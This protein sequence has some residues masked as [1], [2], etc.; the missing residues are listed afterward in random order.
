MKKKNGFVSEFLSYVGIIIGIIISTWALDCFL[1][2]NL[3][4]DGGVTGVSII[5]S[6][7]TSIP[8]G[9]LVF[10]INVPFVYIGYK[11]IGT[12]FLIKSS[13]S[14]ILFSIALTLFEEL[15]PATDEI[16]LATTFGGFFLGIGAGL[17]LRFGGCLDGTE[18]VGVVIS[19]KTSLS[20]GQIVLCFNLVIYTTAGFIFGFDRCMYSLLTY[21][22][23]FKVIDAVSEGLEAGKAALIITDTSTNIG[24][25]IYDKLGRTVTYIEGG[26]M[27]TGEKEIMYCVVTRIE[28]PE[29]KR[30]IAN[31]EYSAFMTITDLSE[32]V[33]NHIKSNNTKKVIKENMS[34]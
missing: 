30:I 6:K 1:V 16:L 12:K 8:L 31:S 14:M 33:G 28:I 18:S 29:L 24:K 21:F 10:I 15:P 7:L 26:G 3:I 23:T 22:I 17:V 4:L 25:I 19:R 27:L 5:I 34:E 11:N 32:I 20:V 2:P 9:L 13:F